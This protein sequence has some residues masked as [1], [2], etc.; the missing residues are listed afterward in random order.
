M[1]RESDEKMSISQSVKTRATK[2]AD[3]LGRSFA[4][5]MNPL[6]VSFFIINMS[7]WDF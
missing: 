5:E 4:R 3:G 2:K 1:G 6:R 7:Q